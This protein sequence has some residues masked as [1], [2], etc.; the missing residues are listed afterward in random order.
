MTAMLHEP[1]VFDFFTHLIQRVA[2]KSKPQAAGELAVTRAFFE[3]FS[4]DNVRFLARGKSSPGDHLGQQPHSYRWPFGPVA[5]ICPFNFPIE[6]P[7]MQMMGALF[8]GNK[9]LLKPDARVALA[10]EQFLRLLHHCGMPAEDCDLLNGGG[11]AMESLVKSQ[12]FRSVQFTGSNKVAEK[13]SQLTNGRVRLEDAGFDWKILGPD[14]NDFDYVAWQSDQDAYAFSGQKCSAQSILFAHKNWTHAGIFGKLKELAARRKL[15]DLTI[16]PVLS[17]SNERIEAHITNLLAIPGAKVLFGGSRLTGHS[18]PPVYG[19]FQPTAVYVPFNQIETH[20]ETV[21]TELFG[22]LQVVTE[23]ENVDDV[24]RLIEKMPNLLTAGVVSRD[25][26]FLNHVLAGTINGV[27]YAGPRARTTGA[28]QNHWF[29]PA[30]D[31]RGAGIG[32]V[33]AIHLVW[34]CHR[35]IILDQGPVPSTWRLPPPS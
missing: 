15:D 19:A 14:V 10:A 31:P 1:E 28:P 26:Q 9:V 11:Q 3:N 17:W 5:V 32:T 29:G 2:P 25:S 22:P 30:G 16:T 21:T 33:E 35:E 8:M 12:V 4:G 34:S 6:I 23:Y 18:I 24:L 20:F 27:T 13:L 7:I